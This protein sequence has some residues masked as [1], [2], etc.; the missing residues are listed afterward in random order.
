MKRRDALTAVSAALVATSGCLG[1]GEP[2]PPGDDE[3]AGLPTDYGTPANGGSRIGD[4][5]YAIR[6]TVVKELL[7]GLLVS[8]G[9]GQKTALVARY[10]NERINHET[11]DVGE[12][13]E[14]T[15]SLA[16]NASFRNRMPVLAV[17][18]ET[19]AKNGH[20]DGDVEEAPDVPHVNG[21]P[22]SYN[23]YA[24]SNPVAKG[25]VGVRYDAGSGDAFAP[26]AANLV[27][28]HGDTETPWHELAEDVAAEQ[29]VPDG[30]LATFPR[31][32]D[33]EAGLLW[34]APDRTWARRFGG[35]GFADRG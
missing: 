7:R 1:A 2:C 20:T 5:T 10:A 27:V 21:S 15:G 19:L 6:G 16:L 3:I 4:A 29:Q 12:C 32:A 34:R 9:S 8:D 26:I 24:D 25:T 35:V 33:D 31:P 28:I 22:V 13:V 17:T 30:S 23:P 11:F 18:S 14:A